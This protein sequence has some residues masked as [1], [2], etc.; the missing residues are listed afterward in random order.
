[1]V[2]SGK[3]TTLWYF[4]YRRHPRWPIGVVLIEEHVV[5]RKDKNLSLSDRP[6]L[7]ARLM[8]CKS[9]LTCG[10]LHDAGLQLI[11]TEESERIPTIM[12]FTGKVC[13]TVN[14]S[15]APLAVVSPGSHVGPLPAPSR[16]TRGPAYPAR[17]PCYGCPRTGYVPRPLGT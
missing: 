14:P 17:A 5:M 16:G 6:Y 8:Q 7:F 13:Y 3:P 11:N 2:V 1:M 12:H 4:P 9:K 10:N 15:P